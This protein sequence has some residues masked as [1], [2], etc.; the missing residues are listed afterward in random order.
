VNQLSNAL[1]NRPA[2][3]VVQ[4]QAVSLRNSDL[5]DPVAVQLRAVPR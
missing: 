1:T 5:V 2:G 4:L 3:Q